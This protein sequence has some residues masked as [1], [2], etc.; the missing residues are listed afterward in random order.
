MATY[1]TSAL[2]GIGLL[3]GVS[4]VEPP[5]AVAQVD[6]VPAPQSAVIVAKPSEGS[7]KVGE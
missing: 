6:A 5:Q 7:A 2:Y 1:G 3:Y 4:K